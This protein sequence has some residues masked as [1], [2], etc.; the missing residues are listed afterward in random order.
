M[1]FSVF[2]INNHP[3]CSAYPLFPVLAFVFKTDYPLLT[4]I[5]SSKFKYSSLA[6]MVAKF[7]NFGGTYIF[8]IVFSDST[9]IAIIDFTRAYFRVYFIGQSRMIPSS[10]TIEG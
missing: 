2:T 6:R 4:A 1:K 8:F 9:F 3:I 5:L 10:T 7:K